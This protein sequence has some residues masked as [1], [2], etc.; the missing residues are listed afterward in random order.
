MRRV[1]VIKRDANGREELRYSGILRRRTDEFVC[2]D[3]RFELDDRDLGYVR[4]RRGD[5]FREHFYVGRMYNIFRVG[6]ACGALKGWYCNITRPAEITDSEI[7]ADDLCLD[8]F[9]HPDGR[10]LLLDEE[11]FARLDL[12]PEEREKAWQ[13]VAELREMIA[14]RRPPFDEIPAATPDPGG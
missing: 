13:A 2:I 14:R 10:A 4:L 6:D 3:A 11:D 5:I 7:A 8:L 1:T 9:A 12:T